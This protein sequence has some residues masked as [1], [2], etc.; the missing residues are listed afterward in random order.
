MFCQAEISSKTAELGGVHKA[1]LTPDATHLLVGDYNTVK[2]RHVARERPDIAVM[3]PGWVEAVMDLWTRDAAI[4]LPA[5]EATWRLKAFETDGGE[6][7]MET[8]E[9]G[10][11]GRLSCCLSGFEDSAFPLPFSSP[12]DSILEPWACQGRR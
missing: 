2:Y 5:L 4:D 11:R 7:N 12:P 8:G 1:D 6:V 9:L 10:E 3:A